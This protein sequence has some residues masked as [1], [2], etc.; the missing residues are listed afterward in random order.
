MD[1]TSER[2]GDAIDLLSGLDDSFSA[3]LGDV[4]SKRTR[5]F[6]LVWVG[7]W[8]QRLAKLLNLS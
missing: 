4:R 7:I 1:A 8:G 3:V 2:L 5:H 6:E